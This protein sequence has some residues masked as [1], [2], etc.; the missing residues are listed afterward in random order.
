MEYRQFT[1]LNCILTYIYY[2]NKKQVPV[3]I[4]NHKKAVI[5]TTIFD[6]LCSILNTWIYILAFFVYLLYI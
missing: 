4:N 2:F 6:K 5:I 1:Q 3:N